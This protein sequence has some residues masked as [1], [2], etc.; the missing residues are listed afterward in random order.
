MGVLLS[1]AYPIP[2]GDLGTVRTP[3]R[4]YATELQ[5]CLHWQGSEWKF[6][7][8]GR[9]SIPAVDGR[10]PQYGNKIGIPLAGDTLPTSEGREDGYFIP[11]FQPGVQLVGQVGI[12]AAIDQD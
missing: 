2:I 11:L 5:M 3:T 8:V 10:F 1:W 12:V 4:G 6:D 9:V 7:F